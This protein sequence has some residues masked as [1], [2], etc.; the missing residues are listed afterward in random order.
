VAEKSADSATSGDRDGHTTPGAWSLRAPENPADLLA[1]AER[2]VK[3]RYHIEHLAGSGGM[4][5]VFSAR[6]AGTGRHVAIKLLRVRDPSPRLDPTLR[7][8]HRLVNEARSMSRLDHPHLCKVLE[9]SIQGETPYMV[10]EWADGVDLRLAWAEQDR[11]HRLTLFLKVV[12]AVAAA[13]HEGIVHGDLKP[14]NVLVGRRG[15][16]TIVDF[17]LAR[18]ERDGP[19]GLAGPG[20]TPGYAPPESFDA[21]APATPAADVFSLGVLLFEALTDTTPWPDD[22]PP[23]VLVE[24]MRR[25]DPPLPEQFA[26][27]TPADLQRICL[28]ALE[29]EPDKRYLNAEQFA[30]DLRRYLRREGVIARPSVLVRRFDTQVRRTIDSTREWLRLGLISPQAAG[31]MLS[32][33]NTLERAQ[34]PWVTDARRPGWGQAALQSGIVMTVLGLVV[35]VGLS[36][37]L[38]GSALGMTLVWTLA[39]APT[40]LGAFLARRGDQRV[41][42][43]ML[44]AGMLCAAGAAWITADRVLRIGGT[45][46]L[47]G[48][49]RTGLAETLGIVGAT[50]AGPTDAQVAFTSLIGLVWALTARWASN[51]SGF[52]IASVV[53]GLGGWM[54]LSGTLDAAPGVMVLAFGVALVALGLSLDW[55]EQLA[56]QRVGAARGRPR[57]A[58]VVLGAAAVCTLAGSV[59]WATVM[60]GLVWA[61]DSTPAGMVSAW[62]AGLL[63]GSIVPGLLAY[64]CV[65]RPTPIRFRLFGIARTQAALQALAG[66]AM[67]EIGA[68]LGAP[69]AAG[70]VWFWLLLAAGATA[71]L[72]GVR[73]RSRGVLIAGQLG[74][75]AWIVRLLARGEGAAEALALSAGVILIGVVLIV[76]AW[77]SPVWRERRRLRRWERRHRDTGSG[78]SSKSWG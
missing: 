42:A 60:D 20:G 63:I 53:F 39:L 12:D 23:A 69:I 14:E 72:T 76:L 77:R 48:G 67:L 46:L 47:P 7:L 18:S 17:G 4:S 34:S 74:F 45:P 64:V 62:G 22:L 33:L 49:V 50:I 41:G 70:R 35:G 15:E 59:V 26:P 31:A 1:E 37:P 16:P 8:H 61:T 52:S 6:Q 57:D 51:T 32:R 9:V 75:A 66:I 28:A 78:W 40:L 56:G 36:G 65:Q 25:S 11:R 44:W 73:T 55:E 3:D 38:A 30:A 13:H 54:S 10:M 2:A 58:R 27:D 5:R 24:H 71:V 29:R 43:G 21:G 68:A 19:M